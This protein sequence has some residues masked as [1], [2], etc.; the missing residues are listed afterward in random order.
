[1]EPRRKWLNA[2]IFKHIKTLYATG[3]V[4]PRPFCSK[5]PAKTADSAVPVQRS[6][7]PWNLW[8][9]WQA[10][11][12]PDALEMRHP[13]LYDVLRQCRKCGKGGFGLKGMVFSEVLLSENKNKRAIYNAVCRMVKA[14]AADPEMLRLIRFESA[15]RA[16]S[17][18]GT[19]ADHMVAAAA[20]L[21]ACEFAT[22][23]AGFRA[24]LL[25]RAALHF[26]GAGAYLEGAHAAIDAVGI[27]VKASPEPT[28]EIRRLLGFAGRCRKQYIEEGK[29]LG[30]ALAIEFKVYGLESKLAGIFPKAAPAEEADR[31]HL[32]AAIARMRMNSRG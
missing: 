29:A 3:G 27:L 11:R 23:E 19:P 4:M 25:E 30:L 31:A 22:V 12:A 1:M 7:N 20:N 10:L 9:K 14:H 28:G 26:K 24:R 13:E 21:A 17:P 5:I 18:K 8:A 16:F 32:M 15:K 2:Q 6:A